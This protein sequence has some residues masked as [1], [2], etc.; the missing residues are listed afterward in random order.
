M[1]TYGGNVMIKNVNEAM[2]HPRMLLGF[3]LVPQILL[4]LL[5]WRAW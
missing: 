3:M 1:N 4:L 2:R 5:N